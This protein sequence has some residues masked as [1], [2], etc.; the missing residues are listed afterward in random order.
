MIEKIKPYI[1][2]PKKHPDSQLKALA[3]VVQRFG[4]RIPCLVRNEDFVIIAGH[5]RWM[6]WNKY[7]KAYDLKE[8]WIMN[9]KGE[10]ICGA[11]E[12]TP[13][14]EEDARAYR[15]ADNKLAESDWEMS[16]VKLELSDF[17]KEMIELVGFD[18][19]LVQAIKEDDFSMPTS[20]PSR[21]KEGDLYELD[22]HRLICGDSTKDETYAKLMQGEMA[23][24]VFTDPPYGVDYVSGV[25]LSYE[26]DKFGGTGGKIFNDDKTEEE[27]RVFYT[28]ILRCIH[29]FTTDD[30]NIYWWYASRNTNVNIDAFREA[31]WHYSQTVLWLKNSMIY[32]P[33][34]LYH[35]IYE[36]CMVG[37]KDGK[38]HYRDILFS[39]FTEL[40][41][42]EKK[43]FAEHLDVWYQKRDPTQKYI[44]P[45][46][47]A[48]EKVY[49]DKQWIPIEEVKAGQYS[50]YGLID[51]IT[52]DHESEEITEIEVEG[53]TTKSTHN[54]PFL[55]LRDHM[56]SWVEAGH[57]QAGDFILA[58]INVFDTLKPS[59][60]KKA[61][62]ANI[63]LE[64][65][66]LQ[67][68]GTTGSTISNKSGTD[69]PMMSSGIA[70][71]EKYLQANKSTIE[72]DES[73]IIELEISSLSIPLDISGITPIAEITT[74]NGKNFARYVVN[75]NQ[76]IE[77]IGITQEDGSQGKSAEN[78]S[79]QK[80]W[81]C[82][83]FLLRKVGSV[84]IIREKTKVYNLSIQGIPAFDT[85]IGVSHN[86]QKPVA[87]AERALKRS[88]EENDIVLDAFAGSGSTMMACEQMNRKCR[89]IELDPKYVDACVQRWVDY[90]G[91]M[92]V[93]KNK[94][95][96]T[97]EISESSKK[98][99][100]KKER[101]KRQK[102]KAE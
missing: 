80:A 24:L 31:K 91:N 76:S 46:L 29:K 94:T 35:R 22:N 4:W 75:T 62:Q 48:G 49:I 33:G 21:S 84:K 53:Q 14:S 88:S 23:R 71:T 98:E 69:S 68:K 42:L 20:K 92:E 8:I 64:Q 56:V 45:C 25:G 77:N 27:S 79:S 70:T 86:T 59:W 17:T 18:A 72:T 13:L 81:R 44:H 52:T 61:H 41:T 67:T 54:H 30:C 102:T 3:A 83:K 1:G 100:A 96:E 95:T 63:H 90:T 26:S 15:I 11:P 36:P 66:T 99:H 97:W 16:L 101:E 85:L 19:D 47:P 55:I 87:L 82:E 58:N 60:D 38:V 89:L 73:K 40:W 50:E 28:D 93:I 78:A 37:W 12:T 43:T 65:D 2:N 34:Q 10:T 9:D 51:S 39:S 74:A 5:G 6:M 57:A 7:K 32:S